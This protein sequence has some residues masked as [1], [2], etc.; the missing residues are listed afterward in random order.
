MKI[1]VW[2]TWGAH[3]GRKIRVGSV[4]RTMFLRQMACRDRCHG[5][6]IDSK[7]YFAL[8]FKFISAR[9]NMRSGRVFL[10]FSGSSNRIPKPSRQNTHLNMPVQKI[11]T[12]CPGKIAVKRTVGSKVGS[13]FENHENH[14][15]GHVESQF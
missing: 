4:L 13:N 5:K 10:I 15:L 12:S 8:F 9:K 11:I 3:F 1:N 2:G 6:R 14:G 7:Q